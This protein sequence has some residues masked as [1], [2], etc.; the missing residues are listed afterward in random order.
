[1][2]EAQIDDL[3]GATG[4]CI[5][6]HAALSARLMAL[7]TAQDVSRE[8]RLLLKDDYLLVGDLFDVWDVDSSGSVSENELRG[9]FISKMRHRWDGDKQDARP[10]VER[11]IEEVV[12]SI[13]SQSKSKIML[14]DLIQW[15]QKGKAASLAAAFLEA[16][17]PAPAPT[18]QDSHSRGTEVAPVLVVR[19]RKPIS[20]PSSTLKPQFYPAG[21]NGRRWR[22]IAL[23]GP[24]LQLGR[25]APSSAPPPRSSSASRALLLEPKRTHPA[26]STPIKSMASDGTMS[27]THAWSLDESAFSPLPHEEWEEEDKLSEE[28]ELLL[29]SG[30]NWDSS[31]R[32]KLRQLLRKKSAPP[33]TRKLA[34]EWIQ[35][36]P[37]WVS[38]VASPPAARTPRSRPGSARAV[39]GSLKAEGRRK[40][41]RLRNGRLSPGSA[42]SARGGRVYSSPSLAPEPERPACF[43]HSGLMMAAPPAKRP[44]PPS[45][46]PAA[47]RS[48]LKH[49][50]D[51]D[52]SVLASYRPAPPSPWTTALAPQL[53]TFR[54]V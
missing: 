8:I 3:R 33:L 27:P 35:A 40:A 26:F 28:M 1:M 31:S 38:G 6:T 53:Q 12:R 41:Q 29:A 21:L 32:R 13:N 2:L 19:Q 9:W 4:G 7:A 51:G 45:P 11:L 5:A 15:L 17:A 39:V 46:R 36:H 22:D 48:E 37:G 49:R 20:R 10:T 50:I 44:P 23:V 42:S 25:P 24:N 52:D 18:V 34:P 54:L 47:R 30:L 14:Y 43:H 16:A